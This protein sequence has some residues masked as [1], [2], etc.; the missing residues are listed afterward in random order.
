MNWKGELAQLLTFTVAPVLGALGVV[1]ALRARFVATMDAA[2][3]ARLAI[4]LW[5]VT[6]VGTHLVVF[7]VFKYAGT[8]DLLNFWEPMAQDVLARRDPSAHMDSLSGPLFPVVMAIGYALSG[9][10]YA[11]GIDLPFVVA[12]GAALWLLL[13]IARRRM[14]EAS[15]RRVALATM[16]SPLLWI[17]VTVCTQDEAL[18]ACLLLATFD[19]AD[20]GRG[21]AAAAVAALGALTTKALFPMW[22]LPVLV[23]SSPTMREAFRRYLLSLAF[24][25]AGL[26]VAWLLG[27][28]PSG[29]ARGDEGAFGSSTWFLFVPDGRMDPLAFHT[30]LGLTATACLFLGMAPLRRHEG[31]S[32][33]DAAVRGVV[34]VQAAFFVLSPYTIPFH[35]VHALPFLAW[36]LVREGADERPVRTAGVVLLAG[37]AA[38]QVPS[39][40]FGAEWWSSMPLVS[41]AFA[42]FWAWTGWRA[43]TAPWKPAAATVPA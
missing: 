33:T 3:F 7:H 16:L 4:V 39:V 8:N 36:Q 18:F 2:R 28:R 5:L 26:G 6:R 9:G 24:A 40:Q 22:V 37:F 30:G 42:L 12:D 11:P 31:E 34:A 17:G 15:A 14:P 27:W 35:L 13:R 38:W 1:A 10:R 19:L 41:A 29:A 21:T 23:A 25:A 43:I 32:L 20:R